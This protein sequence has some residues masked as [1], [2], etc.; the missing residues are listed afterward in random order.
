[1]TCDAPRTDINQQ[2]MNTGSPSLIIPSQSGAICIPKNGELPCLGSLSGGSLVLVT[3]SS[4]EQESQNTA[5]TLCI[6][7]HVTIFNAID[8]F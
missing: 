8:N 2:E 4:S 1:M 5:N 7:V 3:K 6:I